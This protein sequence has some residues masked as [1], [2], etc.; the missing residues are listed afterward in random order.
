VVFYESR[1][2]SSQKFKEKLNFNKTNFLIFGQIRPYKKIFEFLENNQSYI[3]KNLDVNFFIIGNA[4]DKIYFNKISNFIFNHDLKNVILIDLYVKSSQISNFIS[5]FDYVLN[6]SEKNYNSGILSHC[7]PLNI[8]YI[9]KK[10]YGIEER[11]NNNK[12]FLYNVLNE[13]FLKKVNDSKNLSNL[14]LKEYPQTKEFSKF[15][16]SQEL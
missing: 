16:F 14:Y 3:K 4:Y 6:T 10:Q 15:L 2:I 1:Y 9:S 8:P 5:K 12:D 11:M 7:I 13:S